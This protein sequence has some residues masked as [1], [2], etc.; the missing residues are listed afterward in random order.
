[1][2]DDDDKSKAALESNNNSCIGDTNGGWS[3]PLLKGNA[4]NN[5]PT[6]GDEN[7]GDKS[8]GAH[9]PNDTSRLLSKWWEKSE[10]ES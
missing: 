5:H 4:N 6:I 2:E 1:M 9:E 7:V 8:K 3:S 10:L